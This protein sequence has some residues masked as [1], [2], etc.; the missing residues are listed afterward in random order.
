MIRLIIID[1]FRAIRDTEASQ[2]PLRHTQ[3]WFGFNTLKH[4]SVTPGFH[5]SAI[6]ELNA[7]S[8]KHRLFVAACILVLFPQF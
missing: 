1:N 5:D 3:V 7:K 2:G 4:C 6:A 8:S